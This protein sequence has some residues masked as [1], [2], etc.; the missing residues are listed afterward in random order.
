L[1]AGN[2][3]FS[4]C[5]TIKKNAGMPEKYRFIIGY[6]YQEK[7][8]EIYQLKSIYYVLDFTKCLLSVNTNSVVHKLPN[9]N[10][11]FLAKN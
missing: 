3:V 2:G 9:F 10:F 7:K 8:K 11:K 6:E 5:L 4:I 1:F